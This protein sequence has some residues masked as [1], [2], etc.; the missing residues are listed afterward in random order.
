M[1]PS[2][3]QELNR[4]A[5]DLAVRSSRT[6]MDTISLEELDYVIE[7]LNGI[8]ESRFGTQRYSTRLPPARPNVPTGSASAARRP[9]P[10]SQDIRI[11]QSTRVAKGRA[12]EYDRREYYPSQ[13]APA[14]VLAMDRLAQ[15]VD[16][17]QDRIGSVVDGYS[18]PSR[19]LHRGESG[20]YNPYEVEGRPQR[21]ESRPLDMQSGAGRRDINI[22]SQL[23]NP[24][25]SRVPGQRRV[26]QV[27]RFED[28][29]FNPQDERFF[30]W[31]ENVPRGGILCREPRRSRLT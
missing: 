1:N 25:L 17:V 6:S 13:L 12:P 27:D 4:L 24:S 23:R 20:Y 30:A 26:H 8:R 16:I 28:L 19:S 11:P 5:Q 7:Y 29:P 10:P 18:V 15:D 22:E 9:P 3:R 31:E 14:Q 2:R 21:L